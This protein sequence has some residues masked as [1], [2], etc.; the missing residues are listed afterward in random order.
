MV[1]AILGEIFKGDIPLPNTSPNCSVRAN[2]RW[3][4]QSGYEACRACSLVI[5]ELDC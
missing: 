2:C 1:E 5:T 4:G 3:F